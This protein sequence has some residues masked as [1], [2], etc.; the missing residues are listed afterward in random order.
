MNSH[1]NF[2]SLKSEYFD[3]IRTLKSLRT[4]PIDKS[5]RIWNCN[6]RYELRTLELR[7][8][9]EIAFE[10]KILTFRILL[11]WW[12]IDRMVSSSSTAKD[13]GADE[14]LI[15]SI[16]CSDGDTVP[17]LADGPPYWIIVH[18]ITMDVILNGLSIKA[19]TC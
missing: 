1:A 16:Y 6:S 4:P 12:R 7:T 17:S 9:K 5:L 10:R 18:E 11:N 8:E 2:L 15:F 13:S 19:R 3:F 14:S